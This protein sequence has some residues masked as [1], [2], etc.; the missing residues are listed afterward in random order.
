MTTL[1]SIA[2]LIA[3]AAITPGPNNFIVMAQ[4]SVAGAA[5]TGRAIA[6]VVVGGVSMIALTTSLTSFPI[7]EQATPWLA[8][9]GSTLLALMAVQQAL[10]AGSP[11]QG[12]DVLKRPLALVAFQWVNPK[13]WIM[14]TLIA[15]AG[16]ASGYSSPVLVALFA[17]ISVTSLIVWAVGGRLISAWA[18]TNHRR[19]WIDRGLAAALFVTAA[20]MAFSQL[21]DTA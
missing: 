7:I 14:V 20:Q 3:V 11:D 21:G 10:H 18:N 12:G 5:A 2:V 19:K 15:S 16:A 9:A 17:V 8:L 6:A 4:A 1:V 13:A